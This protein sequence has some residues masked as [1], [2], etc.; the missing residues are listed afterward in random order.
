MRRRRLIVSVLAVFVSLVLLGAALSAI[1]FFGLSLP[2]SERLAAQYVAYVARG[3]YESIKRLAGSDSS[4]QEM[5]LQQARK[6]FNQLSGAEIVE[7]TIE[8][9]PTS[10]SS[11]TIEFAR[12][13]VKF[14]RPGEQA[15]HN[16]D[17]F[18]VTNHALFGLRYVCSELG[19]LGSEYW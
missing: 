10:G 11:D 13:A 16:G 15:L 19:Q 17:I 3:D 5:I 6:D 9:V 18:L 2:S 12:A 14:R 7:L 4:C 1:A 8:I